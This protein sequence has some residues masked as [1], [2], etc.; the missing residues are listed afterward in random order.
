MKKLL[1]II[2]AAIF[3]AS[4]ASNAPVHIGTGKPLTK[5]CGKNV[6]YGGQ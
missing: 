3:L 1:A 6:W 5:G 2:T 4:C